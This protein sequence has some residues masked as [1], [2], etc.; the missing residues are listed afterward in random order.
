VLP[1]DA[2]YVLPPTGTLQYAGYNGAYVDLGYY[3]PYAVA[4]FSTTGAKVNRTVA[5]PA[6]YL[7]CVYDTWSTHYEAMGTARATN[8]FDDPGNDATGSVTAANGI[9]DDDTEKL[10]SPPY[11]HPLRGI[12]VKIRVFEPD[13]RQI[14]EVTVVQDF[15]PQ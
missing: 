15:L 14:R 12:Q 7:P 10:T 8:G 11:P 1:G 4:H 3:P 5:D 2:S 6:G 9:V 13:S